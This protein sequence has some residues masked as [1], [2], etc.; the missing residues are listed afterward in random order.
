M[1]RYYLA[2]ALCL[3]VVLAFSGCGNSRVPP[4]SSAPAPKQV[5]SSDQVVKAYAHFIPSASTPGSIEL[6]ISPG[7]HVNAN[8]AT[9][10]YLI[11]TEVQPGKADGITVADK[12]TYPPAKMETFPFADQPLAVYEGSVTIPIPITPAPGARGQRT[13]PFKI[14]VQACD[15]EQCYPPAMLDASL[16]IDLDAIQR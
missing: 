8:P 9:F 3:A 1:K 12:L 6:V 14:R 4:A 5:S 7:F 2:A 15:S 16:P 13:I 10:P 11:A